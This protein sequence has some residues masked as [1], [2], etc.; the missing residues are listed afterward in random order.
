MAL[1]SD[2]VDE[3][4]LHAEDDVV[5]DVIITRRANCIEYFDESNIETSAESPGKL[6]ND[7]ASTRSSNMKTNVDEILEEPANYKPEA[8]YKCVCGLSVKYELK[9][10]HNCIFELR[11]VVEHQASCILGLQDSLKRVRKYVR[12]MEKRVLERDAENRVKINEKLDTLAENVNDVMI[13]DTQRCSGRCRKHVQTEKCLCRG[14]TTAAPHV[15]CGKQGG[16]CDC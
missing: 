3:S 16:I 15:C 11:Q 12:T 14:F 10:T 7:D 5:S 1:N 6:V 9:E 8:E 4:V 2:T 13:R